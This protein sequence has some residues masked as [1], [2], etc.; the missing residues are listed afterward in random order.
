M[1]S[2]DAIDTTKQQDPVIIAEYKVWIKLDKYTPYG[3]LYQPIQTIKELFK[4]E[5]KEWDINDYICGKAE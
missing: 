1:A 2:L 4:Q 5:F 3:N